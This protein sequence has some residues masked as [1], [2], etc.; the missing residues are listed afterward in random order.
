VERI[1][2]GYAKV[3]MMDELAL[4]G[5]S[6]NPQVCEQEAPLGMK[7]AKLELVQTPCIEALKFKSSRPTRKL[8]FWVVEYFSP[9][10]GSVGGPGRCQPVA[11]QTV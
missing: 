5:E 6:R 3:A 10:L 1:L 8:F 9:R 4:L 2:I 11:K 7:I